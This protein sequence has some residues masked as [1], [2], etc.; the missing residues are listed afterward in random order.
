MEILIIALSC[1]IIFSVQLMYYRKKCFENLHYRCYF[2]TN[3][4][5]EG[6]EIEFIEEVENRKSL[7]LP[8]FKSE[9]TASEKLYFAG[10]HSEVTDG[11]RFVSGF[12]SV[13]GKSRVKRIWKLKCTERGVYGISN[14]VIVTSDIFGAESFSCRPDCIL[15]RI[16][17]FPK[18]YRFNPKRVLNTRMMGDTAF[19]NPVF[20]D[21]FFP[22]SIREYTGREPLKY[23][24][25]AATAKEHCVMVNRYDSSV[26]GNL[27]V[28]LDMSGRR[29]ITEHS[30]RVCCY[31]LKITMKMGIKA[32][33]FVMSDNPVYVKG[34]SGSKLK[35]CLYALAAAQ[36]CENL[37]A[38][39]PE[40]VKSNAVMIT[41]DE[42]RLTGEIPVIFTGYTQKSGV[43]CVPKKESIDEES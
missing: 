7:S 30:V 18:E 26:E 34:N 3:E 20:S 31:F 29:D 43:F 37:S 9:L 22:E 4:A 25:H 27:N 39:I 14:A 23:I 42:K 19:R 36:P 28:I 13:N 41:S 24:N 40:E 2:S 21:P 10:T 35:E 11:S 38:D 16:T 8:V 15:P 12:F 17:V 33:L 1:V 6:D 32:N 5:Y